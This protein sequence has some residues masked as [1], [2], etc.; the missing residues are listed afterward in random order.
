MHMLKLLLAPSYNFREAEQLCICAGHCPRDV[1]TWS[2]P[3]IRA[4]RGWQ[5]VQ[6]A[7]NA[8]TQAAAVWLR[9]RWRRKLNA[10]SRGG[11]ANAVSETPLSAEDF[12]D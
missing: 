9:R 6:I 7:R 8:L 1:A 12:R 2:L 5:P 10:A 11:G 3:K 4:W